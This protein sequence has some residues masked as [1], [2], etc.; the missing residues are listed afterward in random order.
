MTPKRI[1]RY[2]TGVNA[3]YVKG[4]LAS[5]LS[6]TADQVKPGIHAIITDSPASSLVF[7]G[8]SWDGVL[9]GVTQEQLDA[10]PS[11]N[12]TDGAIARLK[13]PT[14]TETLTWSRT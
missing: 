3:T 1:L 9:R 10:L 13:T 8:Q 11:V 12:L 4:T 5:I 7:D 2:V 14:G 6:L